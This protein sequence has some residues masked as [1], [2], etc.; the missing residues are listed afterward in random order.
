MGTMK[1][2][3]NMAVILGGWAAV[4]Y[5]LMWLAVQNGINPIEFVM[6]WVMGSMYVGSWAMAGLLGAMAGMWAR[7]RYGWVRW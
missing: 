3:L 4:T 2:T 6:P 5:L 7:R 1:T